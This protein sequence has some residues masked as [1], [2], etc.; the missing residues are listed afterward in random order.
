MLRDVH[1]AW[2]P[3][4]PNAFGVADCLVPKPDVSPGGGNEKL[5]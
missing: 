1:P 3:A 2:L 4:S 5:L